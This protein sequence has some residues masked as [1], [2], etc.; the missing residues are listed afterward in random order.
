MRETVEAFLH[1]TGVSSVSLLSYRRDLEKLFS[2]FSMHPERAGRE[3]LISYFALQGEV[4]S[5]SS[6]SRLVSVIR[7]FY[8]YLVKEEIISENPMEGIRAGD[9]EKKHSQSLNREEFSRLIS[10]S[11][12]GFR[13]LRDR[14]MLSLL[15][16][17]GM[18]VSELLELGM[19]DVREEGV[20]C[21]KGRRRRVLT[22]SAKCRD[23]L[24]K[25]LALRTLYENEEPLFITIRGSGMTRQGFWKNLKD[26]AIYC[27]IDKPIS[28]HTL[29]R[30][31]ALHLMEDGKARE[32]ISG[33]LGNAD[34]ASLRNYH[35]AKKG[36]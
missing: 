9:F 19:S 7:S 30:S 3:E 8:A 5:P 20:F 21:G 24:A 6:L 36:D 29:R 31:L 1:K 18:R 16:E 35:T 32:E 26:R 12:P 27:G 10:Y 2:H 11:A 13:G 28:P 34:P 15:C 4:L 33:L 14:A 17:T 22:I 25:Y 23:I